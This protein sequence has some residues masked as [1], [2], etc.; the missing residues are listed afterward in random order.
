MHLLQI[1]ITHYE[2]EIFKIKTNAI[3]KFDLDIYDINGN[4]VYSSD[5]IKR[6]YGMG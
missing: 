2:N 4:L 5:I 1:I 6:M 3:D